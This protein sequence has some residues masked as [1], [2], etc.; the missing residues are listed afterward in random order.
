MYKSYD[1]NEYKYPYP[2]KPQDSCI[3]RVEDN[4]VFSKQIEEMLY[5]SN[6]LTLVKGNKGFTD[7]RIVETRKYGCHWCV[8]EETKIHGM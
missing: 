1:H 4:Q 7:I 8:K 3:F 6:V 2:I 5:Y